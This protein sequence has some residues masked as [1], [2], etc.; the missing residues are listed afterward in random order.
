VATATLWLPCLL[1]AQPSREHAARF[2]TP[3]GIPLV[4]VRIDGQG[5]FSFVVD[6]GTNCEA[7]VS[8][9]LAK[10]LG[11]TATG[12]TSITDLGGHGART[13]DT[14]QLKTL[15]LAGVE[16]RGVRAVVTDLP[17]GDSVLDG[18]LG[19]GLFWKE[20]LTLDY[21]RHRL[22]VEAGSLAGAKDEHVVPMRIQSGIPLVQIDVAGVTTEAGI[23][24]GGLGLSIPSSLV[25]RL[26]FDGGFDTVAFGR[27]QVSSF[28]LRGAVLDGAVE[29]A[30]SEF[31]EPWLELNPM[32]A[33]ANIGSGALRDF[34]VT[35]D[36]RSKLVRF[37]SAGKRHHLV[38]PR[39]LANAARLDDLVGTTVTHVY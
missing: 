14:V 31:E 24:S 10:R 9:R 1:A 38:K 34:V 18:V 30:G 28:A 25:E 36:Q 12:R 32:F 33:I 20:L 5:P 37:S 39:N 27:T 16:F 4:Q 15:A 6:T 26:R 8:P 19:F 22:I 7:I 35:F 17:D 29:V 13:L 11:L 23:D 21:P 2:S 3:Q